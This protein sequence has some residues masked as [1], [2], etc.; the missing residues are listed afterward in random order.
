MLLLAKLCTGD[1]T[2]FTHIINTNNAKNTILFFS[3][4]ENTVS[5]SDGLSVQF[6]HVEIF[7]WLLQ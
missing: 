6:E 1:L 2:V 4:Q 7:T 5:D 3:E